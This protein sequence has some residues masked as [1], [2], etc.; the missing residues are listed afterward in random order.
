MLFQIK[1]AYPSQKKLHRQQSSRHAGQG[2]IERYLPLRT[3]KIQETAM[4]EKG[5]PQE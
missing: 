5:N 3:Q 1:K 2:L 4:Q